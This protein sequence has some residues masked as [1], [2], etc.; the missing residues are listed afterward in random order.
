MQEIWRD[1][2][3]YEGYYQISNLGNVR[4][5][6]RLDNKGRKV[7]GK[8]ITIKRSRNNYRFVTLYKDGKAKMISIHRLVALNFLPNPNNFPQ[9]NHKDEDI[10][11][12]KLDNLEWCSSKYNANY[13]TRN[14]RLS[15][16]KESVK[17]RVIRYNEDKTEAKI[18]S[19]IREASKEHNNN[20]SHIIACCKGR[21]KKAYGYYWEYYTD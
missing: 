20:N 9:V 13:G 1:I 10:T 16:L 4:S 11:N 17:K 6:D 7:Y 14:K 3:D 19:S 21:K 2:K 5:L 12:N 15:D 18:Y 8:N